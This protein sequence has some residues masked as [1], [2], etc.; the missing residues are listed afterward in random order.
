MNKS[1]RSSLPI[2]LAA[3]VVLAGWYLWGIVIKP[4]PPEPTGVSEPATQT[5]QVAIDFGDYSEHQ[6]IPW[7][8]GMTAF[9]ALK[10][11]LK[12]PGRIEYSGSGENVFIHAVDD[13]VNE[14]GG[15]AKKN[16]LFWVNEEIGDRSCGSYFLQPDD[17]VQWKHATLPESEFN[18]NSNES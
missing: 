11:Q 3:L 12:D 7:T 4:K 15:E 2:A 1:L 16:W 13:Y 14:G 9:D 8:D 5:V 18:G 6:Q 17:T 10:A